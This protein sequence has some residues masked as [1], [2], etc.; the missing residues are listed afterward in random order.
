MRVLVVG[1]GAIG[2]RHIRNLIGLGVKDI[3]VADPDPRRP[4]SLRTRGIARYRSDAEALRHFRPE[5][6]FVCTPT[7]LHLPV[8]RRALRAGAH[9]FV[10]K[11]LSHTSAGVN[12][13]AA[14]A[15]RS[16]RTVMIACNYLFHDGMRKLSQT[17]RAGRH[18]RPLSYAVT[19]GYHVPSARGARGRTA[20]GARKGE[21]EDVLLDSGSHCIPYLRALFGS[22]ARTAA[23]T[24]PLHPLGLKSG[25]LSVV[26]L[27]HA[28]GVL[29]VLSLDY[30]R[31]QASHRMDVLTD[32][33]RLAFDVRANALWFVGGRSRQK[34]Y[35]G[36]RDLN[37]MFIKEL[38]HFLA[39]IRSGKKPLQDAKNGTEVVRLLSTPHSSRR[40]AALARAIWAKT[41]YQ[42]LRG[43]VAHAGFKRLT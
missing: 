30:V 23:L 5:A 42:R 9:V 13:F 7:R 27:R 38:K 37:H 35:Q 14:E 3:A 18:G 39:C 24:S 26:A 25:E 32:K 15:A 21:G 11:P 6:V 22:V 8:A 2:T 10:E 43:P 36:V 4:L 28:T 1:A 34:L 29:G 20:Y 33:G 40:D 31:R 41:I 16:R 19:L 12:A 17:L